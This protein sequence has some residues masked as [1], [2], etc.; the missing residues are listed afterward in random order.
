MKLP[1]LNHAFLFSL[2]LAFIPSSL[3][4]VA[5]GTQDNYDVAWIYDSNPCYANTEITYQ[6]SNPC[7]DPF[8][9]S[10]GYTYYFEHCGESTFALYNDDGSFNHG[11]NY[12]TKTYDCSNGNVEQSWVC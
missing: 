2:S 1:S 8:R 6:G 10:N 5:F 4:T 3:A 9:L 12:N 7:G 11:C